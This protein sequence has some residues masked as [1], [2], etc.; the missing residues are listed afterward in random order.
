MKRIIL[1]LTILFLPFN[2]LAY[3]SRIIPGGDTIGIQI[4]TDGILIVGFYKINNK[5]NKGDQTL[6]HGDYIVSVNGQNVQTIDQM[7]K[8]IDESDN[9]ENINLQIRRNDKI[10]N[11]KLPLIEENGKYKTGLFVKSSIKGIG[12]LT[13]IDPVT[14]IYGALGHEIV[15]NESNS[16]VEIKSGIIFENMITGIEKSTPGNAG[17]KIGN[18]NIN[19]QYGNIKK[20]TKY[21][22]FGDYEINLPN[23]E[24]VEVSNDVK[25]GKALIYTVL[26]N[27]SIKE[28]EI[29]IISINAN[30]DNKNIIFK[31]NDK[32]L[33]EKTG[34]VIQGMSGSPI[35]QNGKIVGA[36]T[37]VVLENPISGY[38]L[39]I[40]N[41]LTAGE[42]K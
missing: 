42:R 17:S 4:D 27:N 24:L 9:K 21:G 13:Y 15:E 31:I 23:R 36:V 19:N 3:S 2:V 39:L 7:T 11:V 18:F 40:T 5:F 25:L 10:L 34:G 37:H 14:K 32:S 26:E 29:E 30:S 16:I 8:A 33:L 22:I 38:G 12:T 28:Y 20:N 41:M 1:I 6:Q 35:I